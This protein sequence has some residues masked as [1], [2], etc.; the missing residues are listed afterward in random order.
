M[1]SK[2]TKT[3]TLY[4]E[5]AKAL[6]HDTS[7]KDLIHFDI[8][9]RRFMKVFFNVLHRPLEDQGVDLWWIDWRQ[10]EYSRVKG[11]DPLGY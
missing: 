11:V 10:G 7:M 1:A 2:T 8:T 5:M 3:F 6:E 9:D 4:E